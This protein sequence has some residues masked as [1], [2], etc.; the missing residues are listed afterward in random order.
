M[1][2]E[3]KRDRVAQLLERLSRSTLV[4]LTDYRGLNVAEITDVRR[5]VQKAGAGYHVVKN[6]LLH[7]AMKEAGIE[8][9]ESDLEGPVAVAFAYGD[10]ID[11]AKVVTEYASKYSNLRVKAGWMDG[12]VLPRGELRVLATLP[13]REI[14]LG[15]VIGTIQAPVVGAVNSVA[16]VLRN[17]LYVLKTRTEEQTEVA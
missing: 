13:P 17:L 4:I 2:T 14:L 16:G 8:G 10:V 12:R 7:L 11:A 5:G 9:L 6:T 3:K 15:K 1:P